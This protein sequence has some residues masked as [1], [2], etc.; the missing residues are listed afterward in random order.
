MDTGAMGAQ[1]F[2]DLV[3]A[4]FAELPAWVRRAVS[5]VALMTDDDPP[6][7]WTGPG[8]LLGRFSGVPTTARGERA[9]GSLP[10]RI[11]LYRVPILRVSHSRMEVVEQIRRVL[12]HEIGHALGLGDERLREL[13][14]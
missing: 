6:A 8:Q 9:G 2:E 10:N 12:R 5:D 7:D 4:S 3:S 1:E 11:E 13:D 14:Y